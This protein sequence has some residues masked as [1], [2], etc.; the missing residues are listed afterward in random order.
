MKINI[1]FKVIALFAFGALFTQGHAQ[2][3]AVVRSADFTYSLSLSSLSFSGDGIIRIRNDDNTFY[4]DAPH[5]NAN[6][7]KPVGYKSGSKPKVACLFDITGTC[8]STLYVKGEASNGMLFPSQQLRLN[9]NGAVYDLAESN[10]GFENGKTDYLENYTINWYFSDIPNASQWT[11]IG[12]SQNKIYVTKGQPLRIYD[13]GIENAT[14]HST[15]YLGCKY[16]KG[17]T[18]NL[19]VVQEVYKYFKNQ[20]VESVDNRCLQYWGNNYGNP[21]LS[22]T[23]Q[24]IDLIYRPQGLLKYGEGTCNAWSLF[25]IEIMRTQGIADVEFLVVRWTSDERLGSFASSLSNNITNAGYA[26]SNPNLSNNK[27][28]F[29][30]KK[31]IPNNNIIGG[32]VPLV[33]DN[34]SA[35]EPGGTIATIDEQG[36]KGQCMDN[37][38]S[39]FANHVIVRYNNVF[40]D[41]SYG[42]EPTNNLEQWQTNSLSFF[43]TIV[44]LRELD[45]LPG[46]F[47]RYIWTKAKNT[48]DKVDFVVEEQHRF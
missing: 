25:F 22:Y 48:I 9:S 12:T 43:G 4:Y 47:E 29:F 21:Y 14:F 8:N 44:S 42:S 17:Q 45:N 40:Y 24:I 46:P 32:F 1:Y 28:Y 36:A 26:A 7:A 20:N 41:P 37:P 10:V 19:G 5:W 31:W 38:W 23:P 13:T 39:I 35:Y 27:A 15:I 18:S 3:P 11:K 33:A 2:S 6:G 30:V 34:A 16:G